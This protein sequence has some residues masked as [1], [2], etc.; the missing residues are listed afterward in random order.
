M[1]PNFRNALIALTIPATMLIL[2]G[3]SQEQSP[4]GP[5]L[6]GQ[7]SS[8]APGGTVQSQAQSADTPGAAFEIKLIGSMIDSNAMAIETGRQCAVKA[9]HDELAIFC[10]GLGPSARQQNE[11]LASLLQNWYGLS[12]APAPTDQPELARL[13]S[14]SGAAF[15][16]A[17]LASLIRQNRLAILEGRKAPDKAVHQELLD[18]ASES[19]S[20]QVLA[21]SMLQSSLCDWYGSCGR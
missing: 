9:V 1:K 6:Q 15:E 16:Q 3:C 19:V 13:D 7:G 5:S 2:T 11:E 21:M 8:A 20:A 4:V 14:L 17:A 18:L 12:H 10:G